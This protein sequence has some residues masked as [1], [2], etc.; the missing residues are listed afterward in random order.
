[1]FVFKKI[2]NFN[3]IFSSFSPWSNL[4][5]EKK[6]KHK[7]NKDGGTTKKVIDLGFVNP[8]ALFQFQLLC[9]AALTERKS[10]KKKLHSQN[11]CLHSTYQ[12]SFNQIILLLDDKEFAPGQHIVTWAPIAWGPGIKIPLL[13]LLSLEGQWPVPRGVIRQLCH[14][15]SYQLSSSM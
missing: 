12:Y 7:K 15:K 1:M 8:V 10:Q 11:N 4:V 2:I 9:L 6:K 3:S 5:K 13:P 14:T